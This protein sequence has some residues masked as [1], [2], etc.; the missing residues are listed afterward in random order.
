[1]T[2]LAEFRAEFDRCPGYLNAATMGVP[3][4]ATVAALRADLDEWATGSAGAAVYDEAVHRARSAYAALVRSPLDRVAVG[5]QTSVLA[6]LMA[7][8]VPTGGEVLCV[9]GDFS[10]MVFPFLVQRDRVSV[11][12]VPLEDL[13]REIGP[14]TALVAFS[15]VQSATGAVADGPG[16]AEAA[17]AV[18]AW[19]F[20]DVT[21]AAGWLPVDAT[22]FDATVCAAYKW[23]CAP[24]GSAFLTV[25][26]RLQESVRPL[27]AGWYAGLDVWGSCYGPQ[28]RLADDARRYDVSPAWSVWVGAA[29]SL[30]LFAA[31][32]PVAVRDHDAALADGLLARCG[33]PSAGSAVVT[34]PDPDGTARGRL[35]AAG[36]RVAGRAGRVR[37]AFHVWNDEGD[38]ERAAAALGV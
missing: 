27:Y 11:R 33:L 35:E 30:E 23:L 13:V 28:M 12:Q 1:M 4:R 8:A 20:C 2:S 6:A 5:S 29:V 3:P 16:I 18:G 17:R 14:R 38:V 24:R 26:E 10:S 36:C 37:L 32:D 22:M 19:T 7:D 9:E 34:L 21:Q 25:A 31:V 15:L